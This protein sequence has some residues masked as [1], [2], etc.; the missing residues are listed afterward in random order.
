MPIGKEDVCEIAGVI[1]DGVICELIDV[2]RSNSYE[3]LEISVQVCCTS[4][5][6][7]M[8]QSGFAKSCFSTCT[9]TVC[10]FST[11]CDVFKQIFA[12]AIDSI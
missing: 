12:P 7:L 3:R 11:Y 1:D 2:C 10:H 4:I 9:V 5:I 6:N 8:A